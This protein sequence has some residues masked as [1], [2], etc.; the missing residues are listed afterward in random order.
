MT[1]KMLRTLR[2]LVDVVRHAPFAA[3]VPPYVVDK[4]C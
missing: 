4:V 1:P 3:E 2:E